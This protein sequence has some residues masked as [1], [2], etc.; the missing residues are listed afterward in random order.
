MRQAT[1]SFQSSFEKKIKYLITLRKSQLIFFLFWIALEW[2]PFIT[3][4]LI[5]IKLGTKDITSFVTKHWNKC[6]IFSV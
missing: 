5:E 3:V 1:K 2:K 4:A 6:K